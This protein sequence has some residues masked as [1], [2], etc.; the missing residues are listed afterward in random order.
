MI[1]KL[2]LVSNF[3]SLFFSPL[4][5]SLQ[6]LQSDVLSKKSLLSSTVSLGE[7]LQEFISSGSDEPVVL[8]YTDLQHRYDELSTK[9]TE[10]LNETEASLSK[11][12]GLK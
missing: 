9:L 10:K 12:T 1:L 6:S 3:K 4:S 5:P 7:S 2:N 8:K 11:A